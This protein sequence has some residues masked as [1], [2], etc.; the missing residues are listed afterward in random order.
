MKTEEEHFFIPDGC[1]DQHLVMVPEFA[2]IFKERGIRGVGTHDVVSSY[3]K[4]TKFPAYGANDHFLRP[5]ILIIVK[6]ML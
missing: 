2:S 3:D 4:A 5:N 1:R 6:L